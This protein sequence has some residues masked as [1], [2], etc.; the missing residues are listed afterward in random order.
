MATT[1]ETVAGAAIA[2][3]VLVTVPVLDSVGSTVLNH[4]QP[5][6]ADGRA[7]DVTTE[8]ALLAELL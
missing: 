8:L 7:P 2:I 1:V 6:D 3:P 5:M 4:A